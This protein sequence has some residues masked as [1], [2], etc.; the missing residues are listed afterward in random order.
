MRNRW[1][2]ALAA[3]G[4]HISIGSVYA[5]S[6]LTRPIMAELGFTLAETTWTF[7]LAILF[8]GMSAGFLGRF[9]EKHGPKKSG[10]LAMLFFGTGMFGTALALHLHSLLLLYLFYGVIGGIGL[11]VG[12]ITPVSTLV[13]YFPQH[14]GFATGLAI[15]GFGFAALIAGPVMQALT[16]KAGL[17]DTFLLLGAAYMLLMG[18]SA[19]YLKPPVQPAG[20]AKVTQ[21]QHGATAAEAV[22]TW[23]FGMLWWV[24]F[25]NITC[26]IGLL[27][28][29]S[30]M[31]QQAAGMDAAQAASM[32]GLIGLVNGG[33]RIVW[34]TLS[35]YLGRGLTYMAFFALE[36]GAFYLLAGTSDAL[37]F[38]LLVFL[39]ISCYGGG[40]SCMPAYLADIFGTRELSAIHGRVLT[41]WGMAGVAG[42]T[43]VSWFWEHTHSYSATLLFF[44][45]CF[46]LNFL[47][48]A[49]LK[50]HGSRAAA[51]VKTA[52]T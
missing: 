14:R 25:V 36:A 45:G 2:I 6:V 50:L 27:A 39:I 51:A 20:T 48:A 26:G 35:D 19:L 1:L 37:A 9:V 17:V 43:I 38:Q 31:A 29:A 7:S 12:Y 28:V 41:A 33:G 13:K 8:L 23:P 52:N 40:F 22:R 4:I 49:V 11:G 18:A 44:A 3:V 30:P 46:V 21:I 5:W 24:F 32:V 10:L 47:L 34:S 16:A 42:P 15:M